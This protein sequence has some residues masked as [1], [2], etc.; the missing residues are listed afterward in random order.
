MTKKR[1]K[2]VEGATTTNNTNATSMNKINEENEDIKPDIKI[3]PEAVNEFERTN[4]FEAEINTDEIEIKEE[5]D[6]EPTNESEEIEEM[7][8]SGIKLYQCDTCNYRTKFSHN[9][10]THKIKHL[11][12]EDAYM[13]CE[14][15]SFKSKWETTY[16]NHMKTKHG[17]I[18][19]ELFKCPFC[20]FK[21]KNKNFLIK[22]CEKQHE[23]QDQTY[24]NL[25]YDSQQTK[26]QPSMNVHVF[27]HVNSES[28]QESDVN[29]ACEEDR[30]SNSIVTPDKPNVV[31]TPD[32]QEPTRKSV[33]N[34]TEIK[35]GTKDSKLNSKTKTSKKVMFNCTRC[36]YKSHSQSL[37]DYHIL[38]HQAS[39]NK[40]PLNCKKCSYTTFTQEELNN[41]WKSA[42]H[43]DQCP[44]ASEDESDYFNHTIN[45]IDTSVGADEYNVDPIK[46]EKQDP[47]EEVLPNVQDFCMV[48]IK[49]ERQNL[50]DE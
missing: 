40:I 43:C 32:I 26:S 10:R 44:Y 45:H 4:T 35:K 9:L 48:T 33:K 15:C 38:K 20:K 21:T 46:E 12:G 27:T 28:Q 1:R 47:E 19:K 16:I 30:E 11:S 31:Q 7:D 39:A 37:L 50:L 25:I 8:S 41:H 23:D 13:T 18:L 36:P 5:I 24:S 22:H 14:Y 6:C 49:E 3:E 2:I 34:N 17:V 29:D 42:F